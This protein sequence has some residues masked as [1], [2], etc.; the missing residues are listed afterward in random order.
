MNLQQLLDQWKN[1]PRFMEA[2]S[3]WKVIPA[4]PPVYADFPDFLDRLLVETLKKKGINSL[5]S[6]QAEAVS[7]I[8][9]GRDAV[10]VTPTASGKT[11]C[12]N[13]PV[14]NS[15]LQDESSRALYLFP[16]KALSQDQLSELHEL[17]TLIDRDIKTFTYD[18]D[19]ATSARKVIR[20][21]GHIVITNPDMLHSGILPHHT[22]WN[23]LFENLKYVVIDEVHTYRGIFGSHLANVIRRLKRI[24][25]FYGSDPQFICCSATIA[26]PAELAQRLVEKQLVLINQNGAPA[27]EKHV[28]FY[29]PPV[30]NKEL[31]IRR[32]SI[33]EA[34]KVASELIKNQ[35]QTIVFARSRVNTEILVTY[36]KEAVAKKTGGADR[37]RGYRGGYLP[38]Q[39]REIER[40]LRDGS[41]L[42]VVSTN[43]LELGI[44][45]GAL[46]AC[47]MVGYPG[48][49]ASTWQQAGR[50][51]RKNTVSA[52]IMISTSS[53]L[54]QFL[55]NHP[56][57]F[58]EKTPEMG[59]INPNNLIILVN[60]IKCASFELPFSEDENYGNESL[61]EILKYL[62]EEKVLRFTNNRYYWMS[63][64]FPAENISLRTASTENVVILDSTDNFRV[65]GETDAFTAPQLV[66]KDAIYLHES[67]QYQITELD[68]NGKRAIA[69]PVNVDYY[70]DGQDEVN[71]QVLDDVTNKKVSHGEKH[72][73]EVM[74]R[75][76]TTM[77][78]KIKFHT[79]ENVGWGKVHLPEQQME[80]TAYWFQFSSE[81]VES[82]SPEAVQEALSGL[83]NLMGNI[84]P[85]YL[86]C[87]P[88]DIRTVPQVRSPYT[89]LPT[90][91][92]YDA[93]PG[94]IG[95]AEKLFDIHELLI[96]SACNALKACPCESGC[97]SC[98]GPLI[99]IGEKGKE[100]CLQMLNTMK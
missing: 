97:P 62:V 88:R 13:L 76:L 40:G 61:K 87:D 14:L 33:S 23:K 44:D 74:V 68:W 3:E 2:I 34:S 83:A 53:P 16:T 93:Y 4:R 90:L 75:R 15:I 77:Y 71:I 29:N 52:A 64:V 80:T 82:H 36:L 55:M 21:A 86:M 9:S 94:G 78:K 18:G 99:E 39:R 46:E 60:H 47:V 45:I 41:V 27:G 66:H 20:T 91:Y 85:V 38:L 32:S 50:A 24:C 6:H 81:M 98:V 49:I 95:L 17:V 65:I 5:Y 57:Y 19:T 30:V 25:K 96:D 100:I 63:D 70:T 7:A 12:Y 72:W 22:S 48:T 79:H 26:N 54:D 43:A 84:A 1:D 69:K 28:I 51:G 58:F 35:I 11:L 89:G 10:I 73:G 42:G 31:G 37:V 92:I 56:E 67:Q 59:L 8:L